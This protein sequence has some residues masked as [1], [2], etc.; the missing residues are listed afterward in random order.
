MKN[1]FLKENE[2][3]FINVLDLF[4]NGSDKLRNVSEINVGLKK[5]NLYINFMQT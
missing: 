3:A 4:C 2:W 1:G 5:N